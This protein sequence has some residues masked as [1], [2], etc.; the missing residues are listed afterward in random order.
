MAKVTI[1]MP[2]EL[3]STLDEYADRN[4]T[5]RS[6][7]I[8]SMVNSYLTSRQLTSSF[9]QV[10]SC[11]ETLALGKQLSDEEQQQLSAFSALAKL[12]PKA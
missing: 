9:G 8:T 12:M 5:T 6:G 4:Y 1:T 2:D 11:L 7:A 10:V 3:L